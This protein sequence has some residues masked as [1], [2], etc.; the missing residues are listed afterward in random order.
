V[1][2]NNVIKL[3]KY[4]NLMTTTQINQLTQEDILNNFGTTVSA[5][6]AKITSVKTPRTIAQELYCTGDLWVLGQVRTVVNATKGVLIPNG[7][8]QNPSIQ[9][10]NSPSSGLY[11]SGGN[12]SIASGGTT[13]AQF[14]P[15]VAQIHAPNLS[16]ASTITTPSGDLILQPAGSN[17]DIAGRNLVNVGS[18]IV[19]PNKYEI[20]PASGIITVGQ[21]QGVVVDI[22]TLQNTVYLLCTN[23]VCTTQTGDSAT[24]T[25]NAKC[26]NLNGVISLV[27]AVSTTIIDPALN[28]VAVDYTIVGGSVHV[29]C[30][31]ISLQT[32]QW[33]GSTS[34]LR[35]GL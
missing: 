13:V 35:Q 17:I 32:I 28:G 9:F 5:G 20:T 4:K 34:I 27:N 6:I 2:S 31:G 16:V 1:N 18:V 19:N 10:I 15:S 33:F 22:L 29:V 14:S 24:F 23:V 25:V 21:V 30:S 8:L 12:I 7:T 3:Y 11:K 26:K